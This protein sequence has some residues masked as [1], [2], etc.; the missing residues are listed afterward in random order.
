MQ[1]FPHPLT[2]SS[3]ISPYGNL[4]NLAIR[5]YKHG[6]DAA[7]ADECGPTWSTVFFSF[8]IMLMAT[9]DAQLQSKQAAAIAMSSSSICHKLRSIILTK[10]EL[11]IGDTLEIS[12]VFIEL[13]SLT[14][15]DK[16]ETTSE[17]IPGGVFSFP[18][19]REWSFSFPGI[20]G[21]RE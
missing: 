12:V 2:Q 14:S 7:S 5:S 10:H 11:F 13:M 15:Y 9:C 21:A 4:P 6:I 16:V 20:P 8:C 3:E 19:I 18:G 17:F 1:T